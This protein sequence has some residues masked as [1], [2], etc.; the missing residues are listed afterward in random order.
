MLFHEN[1][2]MGAHP[3]VPLAVDT[4]FRAGNVLVARDQAFAS[5]NAVFEG[6]KKLLKFRIAEIIHDRRA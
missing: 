6:M 3:L 2:A 4:F 5:L 1:T